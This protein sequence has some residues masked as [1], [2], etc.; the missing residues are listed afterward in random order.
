M[1]HAQDRIDQDVR[2]AAAD[3]IGIDSGLIGVRQLGVEMGLGRQ[4]G[5]GRRR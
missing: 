5:Q 4:D 2:I 1:R 3:P